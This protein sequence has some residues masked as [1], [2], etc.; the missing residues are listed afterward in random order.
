[1]PLT[2]FH[3]GPVLLLGLIFSKQI[4]IAAILLASVVIDVRTVYCFL[5][6]CQLHGPL[7]TY[8]G[9]TLFAFSIVLIVYYSK[10]KLSIISDK[11]H[12]EQTYSKKIN[13][14][15]FIN[16]SMEPCFF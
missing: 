13:Y 10:N 8:V 3:L 4:N 11:L 16:W 15:W 5:N 1:L 14:S 2:P 7:H 12:L 6:D 9:A